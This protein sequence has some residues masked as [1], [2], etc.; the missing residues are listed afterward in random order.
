MNKNI[1]ISDQS[2]WDNTVNNLINDGSD[3]LHILADFDRTMTTAFINDKNVPSLIS[4]LRDHNYLTPDY[5]QK[6]HALYNKYSVMESDPKLSDQKKKKSM[7]EWWHKSFKLLIESGLTKKDIKNAMS[8]NK[9]KLR[10]GVNDFLEKLSKNNIPLIIMSS[11]G[12][13]DYSIRT[14]LEYE[15]KLTNNITIISNRFTWDKTGQ[16]KNVM[17]PIIHSLNKD[18]TIIKHFPIYKKIK[19]RTNIILLGDVPGDI[20]MVKG[21]RYKNLLKIGFLNEKVT[22]HLDEYKKYFDSIITKDGPFDPINKL[23]QKIV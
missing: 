6:A 15:N 23:I 11:S 8:S 12:I 7:E 5:P 2:F 9:I 13:G 4:V 14:F 21:F 18:E 3:K 20:G 22:Q 16:A 1:I 10:Q 19:N 17:E